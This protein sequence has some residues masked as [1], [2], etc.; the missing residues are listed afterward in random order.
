MSVFKVVVWFS[1]SIYDTCVSYAHTHIHDEVHDQKVTSHL[2]SLESSTI[3]LTA[4]HADPL[5]HRYNK[6]LC[7]D[8]LD[9][10]ECSSTMYV[11]MQYS[12]IIL[13]GI[14][15]DFLKI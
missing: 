13:R 7:T 12:R 3:W 8:N 4:K 15:I 11:D 14:F 6:S 9:T 2:D 10:Q 5:C 1:C